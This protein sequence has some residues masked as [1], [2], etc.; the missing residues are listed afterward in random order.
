MLPHCGCDVGVVQTEDH[1]EVG[2]V[3]DL[4]LA[5]AP[6]QEISVEG[7]VYVAE[8]EQDVAGTFPVLCTGLPFKLKFFSLI[9]A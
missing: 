5:S 4:R 9:K 7:H 8:K 2:R 1:G 3:L 6:A